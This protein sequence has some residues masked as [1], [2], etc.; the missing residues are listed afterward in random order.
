MSKNVSINYRRYVNANSTR[1]IPKAGSFPTFLLSVLVTLVLSNG[2]TR[3][4]FSF[5]YNELSLHNHDLKAKTIWTR[6]STWNNYFQDSSPS[7]SWELRLSW[8][9]CLTETGFQIWFQM[10]MISVFSLIIYHATLNWGTCLTCFRKD[11]PLAMT[12]R[13]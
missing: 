3:I 5:L 11:C 10:G 6:T 7:W 1:I 8:F 12:R 4:Y 13:K 2:H 9:N